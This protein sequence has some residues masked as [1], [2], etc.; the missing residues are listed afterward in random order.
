MA[1]IPNKSHMNQTEPGSAITLNTQVW[2][3]GKEALELL[4]LDV[5][6]VTAELQTL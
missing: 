5:I 1:T 2:Q 6:S 3:N 4:R